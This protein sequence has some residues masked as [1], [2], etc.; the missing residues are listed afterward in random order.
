MELIYVFM[1]MSFICGGVAIGALALSECNKYTTARNLAVDAA[2]C[3]G[4]FGAL[5][6]VGLLFV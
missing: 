1:G 5:V 2:S 3:C 6:L 4:I